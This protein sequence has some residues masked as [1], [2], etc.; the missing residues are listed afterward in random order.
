MSNA[1]SISWKAWE[2]KKKLLRK[3]QSDLIAVFKKIPRKQESQANKIFFLNFTGNWSTQAF[4]AS[5]FLS[6]SVS[7][8][9]RE[10]WTSISRTCRLKW[11]RKLF[12]ASS[13]ATAREKVAKL[14]PF[15][16]LLRMPG[17][18][19]RSAEWL[20]LRFCIPK[21]TIAL[22]DVAQHTIP[23]QFDGILNILTRIMVI[24]RKAV[25]TV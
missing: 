1:R 12:L 25:F 15:L 9:W 5:H 23:S 2:Q 11:K 3:Q 18:L 17:T 21:H 4:I 7:I 22:S 19:S 6:M 24:R 10:V 16:S 8:Y 14:C 20:L 13:S